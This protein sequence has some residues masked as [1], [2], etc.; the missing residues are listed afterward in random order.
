[1]SN[2]LQSASKAFLVYAPYCADAN[3]ENRRDAARADHLAH[4]GAY[5]ESK[6]IKLYSTSPKILGSTLIIQ[7][8]TLEEVRKMVEEDSFYKLNVWDKEKLSSFRIYSSS[9]K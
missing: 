2:F 5:F 9:P 8:D 6:V 1:M 3:V 4:T 7:M